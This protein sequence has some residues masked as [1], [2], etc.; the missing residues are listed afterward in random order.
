MFIQKQIPQETVFMSKAETSY[1]DKL[2]KNRIH[3]QFPKNWATNQNKTNIIGIRSM[4]I[5]KGYR[6]AE[7]EIKITLK[8]FDISE[9]ISDVETKIIKIDK[10]FD[11][12]TLLKEFITKINDYI[13]Y[14]TWNFTP[15]N[16]NQSLRCYYDFIKDE[17]NTDFDKSRFVLKSPYNELPEEDRTTERGSG[18]LSDPITYFFEFEIVS[19]NEDCKHILNFQSDEREDKS[20]PLF[21]FDVWDR[22][23]CI[24]FSNLSYMSEKSFLGH[25]RKHELNSIK[26]Y[27]LTNSNQSFWVDMYAAVDHKAPVYLPKDNKEELYI[28]AQLLISSNAVL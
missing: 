13:Q 2:I 24:L 9:S 26:Y 1:Q 23:S 12:Y 3:F 25:T 18:G 8:S 28:E 6:N 27:E 22:N 14:T 21:T 11:D 17:E 19:M 15:P 5:T 4:Y 20:K 7:I 10:F 16:F